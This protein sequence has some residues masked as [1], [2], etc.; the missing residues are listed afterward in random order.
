MA[1]LFLV[2]AERSGSALEEVVVTPGKWLWSSWSW[3]WSLL[4]SAMVGADG[5]KLQGGGSPV[6]P[7]SDP[8]TVTPFLISVHL[9]F[10]QPPTPS[11][12][13]LQQHRELPPSRPNHHRQP[14]D[15]GKHHKRCQR[16]KRYR[17]GSADVAGPQSRRLEDGLARGSEGGNQESGSPI[18]DERPTDASGASVTLFRSGTFDRL[19]VHPRQDR[20]GHSTT[21]PPAPVELELE[22]D[23]SPSIWQPRG[24][25]ADWL[26]DCFP[27][28]R[29]GFQA[30]FGQKTHGW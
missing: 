8:T 4:R 28:V 21:P 5:I 25:P 26:R 13:R 30:I 14:P 10:S 3:S 2:D 22:V 16:C 19:P 17:F 11:I 1:G 12:A 9:P 23:C 15:D 24:T 20:T 6:Y 29:A 18:N 7:L 27:H